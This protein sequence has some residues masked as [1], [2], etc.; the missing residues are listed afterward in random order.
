VPIYLVAIKLLALIFF[1][2]HVFGFI[3]ARVVWHWDT[4][5]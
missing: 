5:L 1:F 4:R 3:Y 2:S